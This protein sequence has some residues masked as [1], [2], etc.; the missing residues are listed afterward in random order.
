MLRAARIRS[1]RQTRACGAVI[2]IAF[3][4]ALQD[5][6]AATDPTQLDA[7]SQVDPAQAVSTGGHNIVVAPI[8]ISNPSVGTG[9]ALTGMLLYKTDPRSPESFT[10]LGAGYLS[11]H[12]WLVGA[13]EKLNFDAD[14]Y[15]LSAG[16]GYGQVNY[17]FFGVGAGA[18]SNGLPLEQRV[19][20]GML[21]FRRRIV[22]AL[23]VGL[24]WSYADVKTALGAIPGPL[25]PV[26]S[27]REVDVKI[28]GLGLV[29]SWDTRDR[30]F[31]PTK[32]TYAEFKS[33]FASNALGSDLTFQTYSL[34]W[35]AYY[36]LD[37]PN[38][39]AARIYLCKVSHSAP[40]FET[41]AYGSGDDLRGYEA[42]RYRDH[43][44]VAGQAEY[45]MRLSSRFGAVAFAGA[46]S[47]AGTFGDLFSSTLLPA[48]GLGLRFLAVPSQ[49]V[50]ISVD[51][52]WGKS[53]SSGLYV[54]IGD[55]F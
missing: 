35:N 17:N 29:A 4:G 16:L 8:P 27:G 21:D 11:S 19:F 13:G 15:R 37:A 30:G 6:R 46:G 53:G 43:S 31:A 50:N 49:G 44:M 28:S 32:G 40:F 25:A 33:N 2:T 34:S 45:R 55:S 52:A 20:G 24:R 48:A 7:Q 26:L 36:T 51:Y 41:C 42:G 5:V 3:S 10:A 39:L 1:H 23:H 47:V 12:S 14:L 9:L 18:S 38:V 54:Y 22:A